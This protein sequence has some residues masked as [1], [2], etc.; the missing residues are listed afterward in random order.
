LENSLTYIIGLARQQCPCADTAPTNFNV[1]A[2]GLY[3]TDLEP[4][5]MLEGLEDCEHGGTWAML[6]AARYEAVQQFKT[7]MIALL[8]QRYK[9]MRAP[10]KGVLGEMGGTVALESNK[11]YVGLRLYCGNIKGGILHLKE[12]GTLFEADSSITLYIYNNLGE[13]L[14]TIHD[15]DTK[16]NKLSKSPLNITLPM[17]HDFTNHL[18]YFIIYEY[19][20]NNK[21]IVN[22]AHCG[23]GGFNPMYS[24][25]RP[26]VSH[27]HTGSRQWAAWVMMGSYESDTLTD[28]MNNTN[29]APNR[30]NGLVLNVE[31]YCKALELLT[32]D[33]DINFDANPLAMAYATA[34]RFKAAEELANKLLLSN[35]LNRAVMINRE[36]IASEREN[37]RKQ[38]LEV[39]RYLS[40]TM[41]ISQN[42][43]FCEKGGFEMQ[44]NSIFA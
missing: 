6:E 22:K 39:T 9:A 42:D 41:D 13:L 2:S 7:D 1:S 12:L 16:P 29:R 33:G 21:P 11:Q 35:N 26:Y 36:Q 15:A 24:T 3:L 17:S 38:Y 19:D 4:F 43:C 5:G 32:D 23:C 10:F 14:H 28:F 37:W 20:I 44:T 27:S 40:Q 31:M 34:V 25:Q 18:E 30:F 8:S